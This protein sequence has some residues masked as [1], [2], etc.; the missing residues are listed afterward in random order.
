MALERD[1]TPIFSDVVSQL[2]DFLQTLPIQPGTRATL[3]N[4]LPGF[5]CAIYSAF[6]KRLDARRSAT[7]PADRLLNTLPCLQASPGGGKSFLL[8]ELAA[9]KKTDLELYQS[10][11][12]KEIPRHSVAIS[13]TFNNNSMVVSL[14]QDDL[15]KCLASML[16]T[17]LTGLTFEHY[18]A[19]WV[20][21]RRLLLINSPSLLGAEVGHKDQ[22]IQLGQLYNINSKVE[23][24]LQKTKAVMLLRNHFP[25]TTASAVR[26]GTLAPGH[27]ELCAHAGCRQPWIRHRP[28]RT[29]ACIVINIE[30]DI[31]VLPLEH[32]SQH[33]TGEEVELVQEQFK[34]L[35]VRSRRP[36]PKELKD[37]RLNPE[38]V[39][40]VVCAFRQSA[41]FVPDSLPQL[42]VLGREK[43]QELHSP[44]L[45]H[46]VQRGNHS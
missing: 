17:N 21:L 14:Q 20:V 35:F 44:S 46:R 13:I 38:D 31:L 40:L 33:Q 7:A 32:S 30:C 45:S 1:C 29:K 15:N 28:Y 10:T 5:P 18:H 16:A 4:T 34:P 11:E 19:W 12:M 41:E 36:K 42:L 22:P 9:L 3:C 8:G 26:N 37:M 39:Y 25:C 27:G 23:F 43:L 24:L 6:A 2:L